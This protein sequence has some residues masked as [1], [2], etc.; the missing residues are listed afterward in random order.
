MAQNLVVFRK[1]NS[2]FRRTWNRNFI[3]RIQIIAAEKIGIEGR[4]SFYEQTGA[5]RDFIQS[6]LLQLAA[7][8][9]MRL[10]PDDEWSPIPGLRAKALARLAVK[11]DNAG[12]AAVRGQYNGYRAETNNPNS[13]VET[14]AKVTLVSSD[15]EWLD[16]PIELFSGKALSDKFTE[17]RIFYR[18]EETREANQLILRL[19]NDEG[20]TVCLWAKRPGYDH[21]AERRQLDFSYRTHY[22]DLPEAYERVLLDAMKNDHSLFASGKEA[23]AA[24]KILEPLRRHWENNGNGLIIYE[25]G[26]PAEN[27]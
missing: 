10:P 24:W 8:V 6:H 5:L 23:V 16:V 21:A 14:F 9:L 19:G 12:F 20:V 3:E 15:P 7:L 17:V 13:L 4:V 1:E 26:T 11:T 2:L 22:Q 27:I 18:Q 25:P